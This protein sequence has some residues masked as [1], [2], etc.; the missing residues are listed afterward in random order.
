MIESIKNGT[1]VSCGHK[2]R[3]GCFGVFCLGILF[4]TLF[5]IAVFIHPDRSN[6]ILLA[7]TLAA[8]ALGFHVYRG[9]KRTL[10]FH[11][12]QLIVATTMFER[13]KRRIIS[14][15]EIRSI[16]GAGEVTG[17]RTATV[18]YYVLVNLEPYGTYKLEDDALAFEQINGEIEE[19]AGYV[20][21][22]WERCEEVI[23]KG[24]D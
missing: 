20:R 8:T 11:P 13:E 3:S 17:G 19:L 21:V 23:I 4:S 16:S 1:G 5:L 18:R 22:P 6:V 2:L 15:A 10:Y 7:V 12:G 9:I 24:G 14:S